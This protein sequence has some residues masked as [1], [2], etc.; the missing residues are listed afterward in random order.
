MRFNTSLT[1]GEGSILEG[2]IAFEREG[3]AVVIG[4]DTFI[5]ASQIVCASQVEIGDDVLVAWGCTI[6]DHNSHSIAWRGRAQDV[7]E[8]YHG[9]KDWSQ[10]ESLPVRLGNKCWVGMHSIILKGVG[11][12]EG[13]IVAAGSVVTKDVPSWTIAGGNPARVIR[14]IPVDER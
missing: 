12:G 2:A 9:R 8:W 6:S 7:R 14:E 1:I 11:I 4:R 13:A 3:A 10:V 5:G